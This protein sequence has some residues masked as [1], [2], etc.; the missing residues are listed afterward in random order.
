MNQ[1]PG[2]THSAALGDSQNVP[3][4]SLIDYVKNA[5]VALNETDHEDAAYYFEMFEDFLRTE[6]AN[7]T[8]PL[9]FTYKSLG[10]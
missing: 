10:L 5:R 2:K 9:S 4:R 8:K 1:R 3:L 6:V 7:G